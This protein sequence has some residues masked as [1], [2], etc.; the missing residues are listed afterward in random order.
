MRARNFTYPHIPCETEAVSTHE[1]G[2]RERKKL[3]TRVALREAALR[4]ALERGPENVRVTDIADAAGVSPRTYN[5]YYSSREQAIVAA[6]TAER[7]QRIIA[8]ILSEPESTS[9]S[10]AVTNA[11]VEQYTDA[12]KHGKDVMLMVTNNPALRLSY[13]G[14]IAPDRHLLAEALA[15]RVAGMNPL[16]AHVL[17]ASIGAAARVAIEGWLTSVASPALSTGFVVPAGALPDR[18][19]AALTALSPALADAERRA[20]GGEAGQLRTR[21]SRAVKMPPVGVNVSPPVPW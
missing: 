10:D 8:T 12:G 3:A 7:E 11:I 1:S 18:L 14:S 4:L 6:V 16:T 20:R 15:R 2:L 19:R 13:A 5:N 21:S 17:A 9:L